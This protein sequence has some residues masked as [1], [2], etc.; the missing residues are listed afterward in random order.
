MNWDTL[1]FD[2]QTEMRMRLASASY[3]QDIL[4]F[5]DNKGVTESDVEQALTLFKP[6]TGKKTGACIIVM[7]PRGMKSESDSPMVDL[8]LR[9]NVQVMTR[10]LINDATTGGGSGKQAE[11]LK[12]WVMTELHDYF[13]G[14]LCLSLHAADVPWSPVDDVAEGV[15]S[16]MVH[17]E[18]KTAFGGRGKVAT[19]DY[20]RTGHT[21]TLT[22]ATAGAVIYY[23]TDGS[24]PGS[25][26]TTSIQYTA[27]ITVNNGD[28][29]RAVAIL[30]NYIPSGSLYVGV[31]IEN[32]AGDNMTT[33]GGDHITTEAG[34]AIITES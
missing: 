18:S 1:I 7:K 34:D 13:S 15:V 9:L 19:P 27:P 4:I 8:T 3:L 22:C 10:P 21:A 12:A 31:V 17:L 14:A 6:S 24:Y 16:Y 11:T 29:L 26:N 2:L 23:T 33:E 28:T 5:Q 32:E 25:A 20:S 30:A